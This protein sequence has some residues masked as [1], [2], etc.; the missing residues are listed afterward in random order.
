VEGAGLDTRTKILSAAALAALKPPQPLLLA[1]GRFG[2]LRAEAARE[3]A[4]ARER[5]AARSLVAVVR[6]VADE[7]LPPAARAELA[8]ALRVV[9][10]VIIAEDQDL[11]KLA[12]SLHPV[13]TIGLEEAEAR[14]TRQLIEH[15][16]R[17]S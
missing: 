10:Y 8:A 7:L 14:R 9:D 4:C 17:Q 1:T 6:P 3:L 2:I 16:H 5:T 13:E 15:V 12:A 11:D